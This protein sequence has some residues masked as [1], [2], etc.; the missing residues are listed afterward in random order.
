MSPLD[1]RLENIET[2]LSR[3]ECLLVQKS[4]RNDEAIE[5]AQAESGANL[6]TNSQPTRPPAPSAPVTNRFNQ[7]ASAYAAPPDISITQILGWTGATALV[8]ATAYLIRLAVDSGWLTPERQLVL[9]LL[10]GFL[11]IGAGLR[12]RSADREY[13]S[14]LPAG[15]LVV[16]FLSI[17]GAHLYYHFIG[18]GLAT[19]AVLL[20]C[21]GALWLARLFESEIYSLFAVVGSYSAP[22]LL[23]ALAGSVVDMAI[24]FSAWSV[25]FC[26][27]AIWLGVRRIYLLAA[28]MALL[29]FHVLYDANQLSAWVEA[30]SFQAVQFPIFLV[31]AV[32][33]SIR[34][35]RPMSR[36]EA[37]AHL[38]LLL[39]FYALQYP[40]LENN[41][42]ALAPWIS[43]A[44]AALVLAAYWFARNRMAAAP[45]AGSLLVGAYA[46]LVLF[47]AGYMELIP[48]DAAPWLVL[49]VL[50]ALAAYLRV[51]GSTAV[52]QWP[53]RLLVGIVFAINYLR[54]VVDIDSGIDSEHPM[55]ALFYAAELYAA[56]YFV[57]RLPDLKALTAPVLYAG[58]IALMGAAVNIL[59]ER[60][61]VSFA[62]SVIGLAC[63]ALAFRS[64]DKLLGKS[65][66]LIFAA[67]AAKV[68]LFDL[69]DATPLVRIACL[70][71]LGVTLYVGGWMY[72]K[73]DALEAEPA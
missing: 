55:L 39:I 28:Y 25:L 10:S 47:H 62:W 30:F 8:L 69:S 71:V 65:S 12:L 49:A 60:L 33:F 1:N 5:P 32:W 23:D 31:G 9:A 17:Y 24:Y 7:P 70:A 19:G 43:L 45:E 37:I 40:L 16:L 27:Y 58:H 64:R 44:S 53:F 4:I 67:S 11:L 22:F 42:P 50:P 15:G 66:L 3:I 54:V 35:N 73:V 34:H 26:V 59:N 29:G 2:R 18:V 68:L 72:K 57:K 6:A 21:L 56:Y 61:P 13:A 14:L 20:T 38:P 46:A 41:L 52:V 63:L 48:H 51:A 36:D